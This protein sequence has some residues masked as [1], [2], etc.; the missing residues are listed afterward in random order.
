[1]NQDEKY[2]IETARDYV[3]SKS[4]ILVQKN[5]YNLSVPEQKTIAFICSMIKPVEVLDKINS[6]PYQLEYEHK[7]VLSD[8]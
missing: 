5:R 2:E 6:V 7:E 8:M 4:N 3:V 1:M